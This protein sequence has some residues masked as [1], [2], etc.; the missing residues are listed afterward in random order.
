MKPT[1]EA[2]DTLL[3]SGYN[4]FVTLMSRCRW[5]AANISDNKPIAM[6]ARAKM[7]GPR[8]ET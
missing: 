5:M 6:S 2:I 3:T 1:V 7:R 4:I 8:C